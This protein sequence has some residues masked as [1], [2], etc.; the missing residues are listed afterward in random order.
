M[1]T[2]N[3]DQSKLRQQELQ[4]EA[5]KER[6]IIAQLRQKTHQRSFLGKILNWIVFI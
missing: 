5:V 3:Y 4:R 6:Q 1:N 2:I